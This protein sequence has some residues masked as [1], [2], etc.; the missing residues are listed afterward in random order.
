LRC[1]RVVGHLSMGPE[2][3]G[4]P[5]AD[6]PIDG[7][8]VIEELLGKSVIGVGILPQISSGKAIVFVSPGIGF[9]AY[10]G[11]VYAKS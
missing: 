5:V 8:P 7:L 4:D 3:L 1:G 6:C 11:N 2:K 9:T 10:S